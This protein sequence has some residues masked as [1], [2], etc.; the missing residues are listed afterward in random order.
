MA[1]KI[2]KINNIIENK[3]SPELQKDGGDIELMDIDGNKVMVKM[4]G[5]C[6]SCKKSNL[7]L[8]SF[9]EATLREA[10]DKEIEVVQ[11]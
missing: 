10:V 9:V 1:Q 11:L 7:T 4:H 3:I 5:A 8:K 6:S 2:I